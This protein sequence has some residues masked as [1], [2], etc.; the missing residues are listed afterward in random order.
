M[1]YVH[2]KR[3]IFHPLLWKS[4]TTKSR[5]VQPSPKLNRWQTCST[6]K[7][8]RWNCN[9]CSATNLPTLKVMKVTPEQ[10]Y[11]KNPPPCLADV[12]LTRKMSRE[13][14]TNMVSF[15]QTTVSASVQTKP[16]W[17]RFVSSKQPW[18]KTTPLSIF[19]QQTRFKL[20]MLKTLL[21]YRMISAMMIG[22]EMASP[23]TRLSSEGTQ[24]LKKQVPLTFA[25]IT[26][27]LR[28]TSFTGKTRTPVTSRW[29]LTK[30][31]SRI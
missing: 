8:Q 27:K 20:S 9:K 26:P 6:K 24:R 30:L 29:M 3:W 5:W 19:I 2:S 16:R 13:R 21:T 12:I 25:P 1:T 22:K 11:P 28:R 10:A 15:G 31:R 17:S 18:L 14:S 4:S 7:R 23:S